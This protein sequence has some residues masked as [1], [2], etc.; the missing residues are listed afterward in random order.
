[1][2]EIAFEEY[3][4]QFLITFHKNYKYF[5]VYNPLITLCKHFYFSDIDCIN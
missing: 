5:I 2:K 3:T 1:M 4:R